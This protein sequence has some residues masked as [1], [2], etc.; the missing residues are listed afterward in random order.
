MRLVVLSDVHGNLPALEAVIDELSD[1]EIDGIIFAGDLVG[2]PQPVETFQRLSS[3]GAIMISGNSDTNFFKLRTGQAPKEWYESLQFAL[4][5][6]AD[7][8]IDDI[9]FNCLQSLPQQR[10]IKFEGTSSIRVVHGSP[11]NQSEE[12]F[13]D[14]NPEILDIALSQIDDPVFVC[15]H[16]HIPWKIEVGG[17]LAFN[18]GAVCGPLNGQVCA[19]YAIMNWEKDC[20]QVEHHLVQYDLDLIRTAFHESGLLYEGGAFAR[21]FL[22]SIESGKNVAECFLHHAYRLAEEAGFGDLNVVPDEIWE[23]ADATFDWEVET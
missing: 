10:C 5:R 16:T 2:G 22:R 9:T 19:Q 17:R 21:S 8:R 12:I 4:L 18:P 20:W 3:L 1:H 6:W 23:R 15:G 13:P 14:R 11:R 7:K